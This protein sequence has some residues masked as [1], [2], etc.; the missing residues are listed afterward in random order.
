M[1]LIL[2]V[3]FISISLTF[4]VR[5]F[6][7][8]QKLSDKSYI[9]TNAVIQAE[10]AAQLLKH[11]YGKFDDFANYYGIKKSEVMAVYFDQQFKVCDDSKTA[12]YMLLVEQEKKENIVFSN[13]KISK[14]VNDELIY[15]IDTAVCT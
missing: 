6:W 15:S 5:F 9:L 12:S 7:E 10:N 8:S 2:V 11:D 4:C 1:E 13:I 14:I 3:L